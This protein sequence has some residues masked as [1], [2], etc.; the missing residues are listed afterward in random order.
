VLVNNAGVEFAAAFASQPPEELRATIKVN[1][2]TPLLLTRRVL[3]AC[4]SG[5]ASTSC[6]WPRAGKAPTPYEAAY[7]ASK[8]G[9]IDL[10]QSLRVEYCDARLAS[11]S[12]APASLPATG[13]TSGSSS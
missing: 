11:P 6:S 9:L 5:T 8:A 7:A 13:S 2:A 12:S 10:T 4:S 3:R 1:L